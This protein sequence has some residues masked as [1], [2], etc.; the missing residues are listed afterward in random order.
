MTSY[1]NG[2][3][4]KPHAPCSQCGSDGPFYPKRHHGRRCIACLCAYQRAYRAKQGRTISA[5]RQAQY[6]AQLRARDPVT[7]THKERLYL[8]R[9][10]CPPHKRVCSFGEHL[11]RLKQFAWHNK[12]KGQY[13]TYCRHCR[14]MIDH[15]RRHK[16]AA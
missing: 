10:A 13:A 1:H 3:N 6:Y 9:A 16:K 11:C 14:A 4:T 12:A 8:L 5:K 15:I 2:Q 7:L